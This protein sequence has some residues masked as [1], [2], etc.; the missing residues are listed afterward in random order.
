MSQK[1]IGE[2]SERELNEYVGE[3]FADQATGCAGAGDYRTWAASQG[4]KHCAVLNWTSS[5]GDW[6]FI[7]S[8]DGE[9]WFLMC[10]TNN[11]PR[12]GFTRSVDESLPFYGTAEHVLEQVANFY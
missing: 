8:R 3:S 10:Q 9:E 7:V 6:E 4:F 12:A 2:M 5:A 1:P 11:W